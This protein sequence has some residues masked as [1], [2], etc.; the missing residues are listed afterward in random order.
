MIQFKLWVSN[1]AAFCPGE[2]QL[3]VSFNCEFALVVTAQESEC[4]VLLQEGVTSWPHSSLLPD[5][6]TS[7]G[8]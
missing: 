3:N 4:N 7:S 1:R 5:S 6:S 2:F 8:S